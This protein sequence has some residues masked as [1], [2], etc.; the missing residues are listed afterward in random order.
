MKQKYVD[1]QLKQSRH[2]YK[3]SDEQRNFQKLFFCLDGKY[4]QK[5]YQVNITLERP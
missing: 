5:F 3:D 2:L 4:I 1:V